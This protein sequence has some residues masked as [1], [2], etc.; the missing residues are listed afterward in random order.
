[1]DGQRFGLLQITSGSKT[2][3]EADLE[4]GDD[5][6]G[7]AFRSETLSNQVNKEMSLL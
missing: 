1:V 6:D 3:I 2:A 4:L 5:G 7:Y